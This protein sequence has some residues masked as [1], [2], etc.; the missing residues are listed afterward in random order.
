MA[1]PIKL[2]QVR[3]I[4]GFI[5]RD[6]AGLPFSGLNDGFTLTASSITTATVPNSTAPAYLAYFTYTAGADVWV[7]SGSAPTITLP[8]GT[9]GARPSQ[10]RPRARIV[11]P[12]QTLQFIY[13]NA[14]TTDATVT[15]GIEYYAYPDNAYSSVVTGV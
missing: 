9:P 13:V 7:Q 4:N 8:N 2:Y 10:L 14:D 12:G 6:G 11:V 15:V 3:D 1:T 5:T